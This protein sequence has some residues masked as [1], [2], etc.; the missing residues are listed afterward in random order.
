MISFG[1]LSL[2]LPVL[3]VLLIPALPVEALPFSCIANSATPPLVRAEGHTEMIGDVL[4]T[5]SG[6]TPTPVGQL[7]PQYNIQI[8]LNT[9]VTS[10]L[11]TGPW[12]EALVLVGDPPPA[13][14]LV[15][16]APM[17]PAAPTSVCTITG[18]GTGMW[19]YDG[20]PGH[21]NIF[22]GPSSV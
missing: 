9:N 3:S 17:A 18:N 2:L 20:T 7:V 12:S 6:G 22:Q 14:Q 19:L 8:F 11:L 16:G 21:P 13:T 5:C 4:L 1:K 10:R 15:C